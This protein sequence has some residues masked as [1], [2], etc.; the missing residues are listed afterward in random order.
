MKSSI[1]S[2]LEQLVDRFEEVSALLSDQGTIA[3]QDKFRDLSREFAE[4]ERSE[5]HTSE[6]QSLE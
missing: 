4:I 2:R 6:L 3:N 1:Q 5:E